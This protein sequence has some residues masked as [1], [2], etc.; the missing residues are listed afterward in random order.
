MRSCHSLRLKRSRRHERRL[1]LHFLLCHH[2][3]CKIRKPLLLEELG[4][5]FDS[6][7]EC[8][9]HDV[10]APRDLAFWTH[11]FKEH[12]FFHTTWSPIS[13]QKT[14]RISM[15]PTIVNGAWMRARD[16]S[17]II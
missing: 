10:C 7:L 11:L 16:I 4:D 14:G 6:T 17:G 12:D 3:G 9:E 2:S 15:R 1:Q 5:V 13:M 8:H